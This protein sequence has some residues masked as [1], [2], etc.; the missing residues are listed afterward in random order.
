MSYGN[1]FAINR[2][3][4]FGPVCDDHWTNPEATT[5]CKYKYIHTYIIYVTT[6][7]KCIGWI[8][9][10][11]INPLLQTT[12]IRL[13]YF[14]ARILLRRSSLGFCDGQRFL[15]NRS[16]DDSGL[17]ISGRNHGE[18]LQQGGCGGSLLPGPSDHQVKEKQINISRL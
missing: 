1:V 10:L 14:P 11:F 16:R 2:N 5:V 12:R 13:R 15:S 7:D 3:G 18:L 9:L 4:F 17:R 6:Y 8:T